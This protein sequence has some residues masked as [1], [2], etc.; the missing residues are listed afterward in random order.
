MTKL[1]KYLLLSLVLY[2]VFASCHK[3]SNSPTSS[4]EDQLSDSQIQMIESAGTDTIS[5]FADAL[6]PDGSNISE[7]DTLNNPGYKIIFDGIND[8]VSASDKHLLFIDVFTKAAFQLTTRENYTNFPGQNGVAYVFGS[9]SIAEASTYAGANC[10]QPLYGLD[11]SGM[12]YQM[13]KVANLPLPSGGTSKY[14]DPAVWNTAF[15]SSFAFKGLQMTVVNAGQPVQ[16]G[17]IIV[18]SGVHMGFVYSGSGSLEFFQSLGKASYPCSKNQDLGHGPILSPNLSHWLSSTFNNNYI[19]LRTVQSGPPGISTSAAGSIS[20]NSAVCGGI[21]TNQ[22]QS[23]I[24]ARG[25]CWNTT[26]SPTLSNLHTTDGS[27]TGTFTSSLTGLTPNTAYHVRAYATNGSGT[28]YGN[29]V[30]FTTAAPQYNYTA[31]YHFVH[32]SEYNNPIPSQDYNGSLQWNLV[33]SN[34]I[35]TGT[36]STF[37]GGGAGYVGVV[38]GTLSGSSMNINISAAN[39]PASETTIHYAENWIISGAVNSDLSHYNATV[40]VTELAENYNPSGN[41]ISTHT[42]TGTISY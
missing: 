28:A 38:T 25:V 31:T 30:S 6:F 18:S 10:Q 42:F 13:A 15:N 1:F 24:T 19:I 37:I 11:C 35:I 20:Q 5:T 27:G 36:S 12:I 41:I 29:D 8:P 3:N 9:K 2:F 32:D 23:N 33:I 7:W 39:G 26:D 34:G 21:I 16:A 14:A 4:T 22:G 17:D 40:E